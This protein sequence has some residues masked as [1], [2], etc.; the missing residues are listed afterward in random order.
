MNVKC[1]RLTTG[2]DIMAEYE[3]HD[4]HIVLTN[5]VQISMIPSRT[6]SNST[7]GFMPFPIYVGQNSKTVLNIKNEH[8]MFSSEADEQF[9]QQYDSIFGAGIITPTKNIIMN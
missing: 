6:G 2:E 1:F 7:F 5:P 8:I 9:M 3:Q 4:D